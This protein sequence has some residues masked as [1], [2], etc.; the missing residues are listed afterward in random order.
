M[1]NP[2]YLNVVQL[3]KESAQWSKVHTGRSGVVGG[4]EKGKEEVLHSGKRHGELTTDL[5]YRRR[6]KDEDISGR[7][8]KKMG[9]R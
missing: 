5:R 4:E 7:I 2:E 9:M 6:P 3:F 8:V 1:W